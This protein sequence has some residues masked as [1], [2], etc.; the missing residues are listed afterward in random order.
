MDMK[1]MKNL[2]LLWGVWLVSLGVALLGATLVE[3]NGGISQRGIFYTSLACIFAL[4]YFGLLAHSRRV[5]G[6]SN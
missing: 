4:S 2:K 3:I 6:Q 1:M 5:A